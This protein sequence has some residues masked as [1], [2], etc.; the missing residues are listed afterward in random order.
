MITYQVSS[1]ESL[2]ASGWSQHLLR[3]RR[4]AEDGARRLHSEDEVKVGH[5]HGTARQEGEAETKTT[6]AAAKSCS[7]PVGQS[8]E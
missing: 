4:E 1:P 3:R 5:H 7:H 2:S 8:E 6:N